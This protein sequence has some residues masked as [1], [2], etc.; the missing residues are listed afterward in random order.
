MYYQ[1]WAFLE[2]ETRLLFADFLIILARLFEFD[3]QSH[4]KMTTDFIAH[5]LRVAF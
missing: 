2:L 1:K 3:V 5:Y 4:N